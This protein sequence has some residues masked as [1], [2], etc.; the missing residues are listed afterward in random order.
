[1][2]AERSV[3]RGPRQ[4]SVMQWFE[5]R[6]RTA[7]M[8][9]SSNSLGELNGWQ[10]D[11]SQL[12]NPNPKG[13][14]RFFTIEG[15]TQ[16]P[17]GKDG[18]GIDQPAVVEV[19]DTSDPDAAAGTI[20]LLVDR[21]GRMLVQIA[22][23]PFQAGPGEEPSAYL[24]LLPSLQG[25]YTNLTENNVPLSEHIDPTTYTHFKRLNT[26]RVEGKIRMG[27]TEVDAAAIDLTELPNHA[28]FSQREM[29]EAVLQGVPIESSLDAVM[30]LHRAQENF[31]T[32][33]E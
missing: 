3:E 27:V 5:G 9:V 22:A 1:M 33:R 2:S 28:W 29:D 17:K 32:P 16:Y 19:V 4:G 13:E 23:R 7:T 30:N 21:T 18:S 11:G 12:L 24:T 14:P 6:M 8:Q 26:A 25:S 10:N 15:R 31:R 20:G